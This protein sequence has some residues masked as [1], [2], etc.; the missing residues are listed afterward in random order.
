[1]QLS[2]AS[3]CVS[4]AVSAEQVHVTT[5]TYSL[6]ASI[7]S[8][9]PAARSHLLCVIVG[10]CNHATRACNHCVD[11]W[12][13]V[14]ICSLQ[15]HWGITYCHNYLISDT[16]LASIL[17][18]P[19]FVIRKA[20]WRSARRSSSPGRA[21]LCFTVTNSLIQT[22]YGSPFTLPTVIVVTCPCPWV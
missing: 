14:C 16:C 8:G 6:Q 12:E 19:S 15:T 20:L 5:R 10:R 22:I 4:T 3:S 18:H 2:R 11:S 1:M 7:C 21:D 13:Y 9:A 17:R